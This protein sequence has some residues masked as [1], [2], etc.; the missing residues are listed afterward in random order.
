MRTPSAPNCPAAQCPEPYNGTMSINPW[1]YKRAG[2]YQN[3]VAR[4][5]H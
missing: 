3:F 1:G 5:L 2:K 4:A